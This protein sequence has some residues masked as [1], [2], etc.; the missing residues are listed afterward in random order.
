[1]ILT[2][3]LRVEM[4]VFPTRGPSHLH[5]LRHPPNQIDPTSI[6]NNH[7][8]WKQVRA[9]ASSGE[10]VSKRLEQKRNVPASSRPGLIS[11]A[12]I[13]TQMRNR[14]LFPALLDSSA[15]QKVE[16]LTGQRHQI[17]ATNEF[18]SLCRFRF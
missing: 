3:F 2:P 16:A 10:A 14:K 1:M 4:R 7:D 8:G 9:Q 18:G 17:R 6:G 13:H 5:S 12:A 11:F 15:R